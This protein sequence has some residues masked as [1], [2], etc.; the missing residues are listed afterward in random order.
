MCWQKLIFKNKFQFQEKRNS[1][2]R[3]GLSTFGISAINVELIPFVSLPFRWNSVKKHIKSSCISVQNCLMKP[4]EIPSWPGLLK[5]SESLSAYFTSTKEKGR[6]KSP[7]STMDSLQKFNSST[8]GRS[9]LTTLKCEENRLKT[10][11]LIFWTPLT[12]ILLTLINWIAL[13]RC[14]EDITVG[15]KC[16]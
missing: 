1:C 13:R 14:L 15:T 16:V 2:N 12:W 4:N 9:T 5:L 11:Y 7:D 10:A 8:L 3:W 6:I